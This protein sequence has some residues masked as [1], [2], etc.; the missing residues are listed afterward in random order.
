MT[1]KI[2]PIEL[3]D[4]PLPKEKIAKYPRPQ[5]EKDLLLLIDTYKQTF[6][7]EIFKNLPQYLQKGDLL[8]LNNTKVI[9]ARLIGK[10]KTGGKV[11]VLLN[12]PIEKNLWTALIGG[13]KIKSGLEIHIA[14]DFRVLIKRHI[15]GPLFEVEL[16]TL[17]GSNYMEKLFKYGKIP[18]PPY[19][20]REEE[21]IDRIRY[22]TVYAKKEGSVAAPTAGL[23]F[24]AEILETLKKKG[25]KIVFI[26]LHVAFGTFKPVKVRNVLQHKV[27]PE[28][29]KVDAEVIEAIKSA[30]L[31]GKRVIAVGTTTTRALETIANI[32]QKEKQENNSEN[33][34]ENLK[35]FEGF[36]NLYIHPFYEFKI[37]DAL[38]TN[39][40]L[41]KSSLLIL[42][43]AFTR[44]LLKRYH[45]LEEEEAFFKARELIF[46]AYNHAIKGEY[47]FYSYGDATFI[48]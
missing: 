11:E 15:E 20:G 22:Q 32:S 27:D 34:W 18:I 1:E 19:I 14:D 21:K 36:T 24:T 37:V 45:N 13:K 8:V 40:H 28:Y 42:V 33:I 6:K 25:V 44:H 12:S 26:T 41:P 2:I 3:F 10:K 46:Q 30:K 5:R 43:I 39:F 38:I 7:D 9:P 47:L 4:Y 31:S 35:P 48:F 17:D 23:H 29:L 16:R